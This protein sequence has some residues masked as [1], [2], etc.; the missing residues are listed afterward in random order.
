MQEEKGHDSTWH[1]VDVN[2]YFGEWGSMMDNIFDV[3]F[4]QQT[5][6]SSWRDCFLFAHFG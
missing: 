3:R 1:K 4:L 5:K 2:E 6:T